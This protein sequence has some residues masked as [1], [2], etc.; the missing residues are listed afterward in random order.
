MTEIEFEKTTS[1][2]RSKMDKDSDPYLMIHFS[3]KDDH[4]HAFHDRMDRFDAVIL[5]GHLVKEFGLK[6]SD[7]EVAKTVIK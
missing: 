3:R 4:Y 7:I 1:P 6:Q 2:I 5:L